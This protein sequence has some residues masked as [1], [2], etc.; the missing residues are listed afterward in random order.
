MGMKFT[1]EFNGTLLVKSQSFKLGKGVLSIAGPTD[2]QKDV[3]AFPL[4]L[5]PR[6]ACCRCAA[7]NCCPVVSL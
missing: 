4:I 3:T 5:L 1:S 6:S 2:T 7:S